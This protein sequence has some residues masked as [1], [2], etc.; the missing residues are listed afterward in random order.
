MRTLP[1]A[2]AV[3]AV[4]ATAAPRVARADDRAAAKAEFEAGLDADKRKDYDAA[5]EHYQRAYD[6]APHQNA[7]YNI[8]VDYERIGELRDA[9]TFY[10]RYLDEAGQDTEDRDKV[11]RLMDNLRRRPS[12]VTIRSNPAG[13]EISVDGVRAGAAPVVKDLPGGAHAITATL[14]E[15][16]TERQISLE[17]GEPGDFVLALSEQ[18]GSLVVTSNVEGAQVEVDGAPAGVTP[19]TIAVAAGDRKV[20]VHSDGYSSLERL[21]RVPA[22]GSAQITA[23][24]VHPV[25]Y[26]EPKD[27]LAGSGYTL[28]IG[29]GPLLQ[30]DTTIVTAGFGYRIRGWEA[31]WLISFYGEARYGYGLLV[32]KY[33]G[34]S[35][36]KPYVGGFGELGATGSNS[37]AER[38]GVIG[39]HAGLAIE[40]VSGPRATLELAVDGGAAYFHAG[41]TKE[42]AFP[43]MISVAYRGRRAQ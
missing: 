20:V 12:R 3:L 6:L 22:E 21:V 7:L 39:A 11:T 23:T 30:V 35:R 33:L 29:G 9:A 24:L 41:D 27:P 17:Y 40:M 13:A 14:G 19:L 15:R 38:V 26:T 28:S 8:A 34:D 36:I 5:I 25:G 43:I 31:A 2:A 16:K 18:Q 10:G 42:L 4:V 37:T 1:I 32:R